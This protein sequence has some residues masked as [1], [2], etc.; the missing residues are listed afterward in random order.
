[1][2][3][4]CVVQ[5]LFYQSILELLCIKSNHI[6][7]YKLVIISFFFY[8][9]FLCNWSLQALLRLVVSDL[10]GSHPLWLECDALEAFAVLRKLVQL[11]RLVILRPPYFLALVCV[12]WEY[13]LQWH[14][15]YFGVISLLPI[16]IDIEVLRKLFNINELSL[17]T[18]TI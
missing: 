14:F 12:D 8:F 5:R 7:Y 1:M 13:A 17:Q 10:E 9:F 11:R 18:F 2:T 4:F 15:L 16:F 3:N 6:A